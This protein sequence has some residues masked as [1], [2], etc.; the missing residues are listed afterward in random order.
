MRTPGRFTYHPAPIDP[1]DPEY[2]VADDE[3]DVYVGGERI[4]TV[5]KGNVSEGYY[6]AWTVGRRWFSTRREAALFLFNRTQAEV[7]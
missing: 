7:V 1:E 2:G 5:R 3:L 6:G 4:G